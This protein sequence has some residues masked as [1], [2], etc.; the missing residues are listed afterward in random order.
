VYEQHADAVADAVVQGKSA[1]PLLN[2]MAGSGGGSAVQRSAAP[3][4][5]YAR[6]SEREQQRGNWNAGSGPLRVAED[7]RIAVPEGES[8][9]MFATQGII[10]TAADTMLSQGSMYTVAPGGQTVEGKVPNQPSMRRTLVEVVPT[11]LKTQASGDDLTTTEACSTHGQEVMGAGA[12]QGVHPNSA[13]V[14]AVVGGEGKRWDRTSLGG[15]LGIV[16]ALRDQM[17]GHQKREVS[18]EEEQRQETTRSER[19]YER[20]GKG[21]R[22]ERAEQLGINQYAAPKV[23]EGIAVYNVVSRLKKGFPM[24]FAAVIAKSG[25]DYVTFEN[26]AKEEP[27]E[28]VKNPRAEG[29]TIDASNAWYF[30]MYGP[31][32]RDDDQSFYGEHVK[33]G[34]Q[35]G[36]NGTLVMTHR[37]TEGFANDT[38]IEAERCRKSWERFAVSRM[39]RDDT[40]K[41]YS[42]YNGF[43]RLFI[44]VKEE[45]KAA[46]LRDQPPPE[47]RMEELLQCLELCKQTQ[48]GSFLLN[49][50]DW[51]QAPT[52]EDEVLAQ[53]QK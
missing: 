14:E 35:G 42:A 33:M 46:W 30:R 36:K 24:H 18:G 7:G 37:K 21:L 43:T 29:D 3:V 20:M 39:D 8:K 10:K 1:E 41:F 5:M 28:G 12:R 16:H 27:G 13:G 19:S 44:R 48:I 26:Y 53:R 50:D 40:P 34:E 15:D 38:I 47:G 52:V 6:V 45:A 2:G 32:K 23:G 11:N 49:N 25:G 31:P 4:Q 17:S 51:Q 22:K 9:R